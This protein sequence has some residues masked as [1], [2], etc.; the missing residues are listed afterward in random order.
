MT[1]DR[2]SCPDCDSADRIEAIS[3]VNRRDFLRT[4]GAVGAAASVGSLGLWTPDRAL[5]AAPAVSSGATPES[6]VKVLYEMLKPEQRSKVCYE[7]DYQDPKRGLLRTHVANNWNIN[8]QQINGDFYTDDQ[9]AVIRSIFEG[10]IQPEWHKRIY[11]QLSDDAGGY[12]EDQSLAIFGTPG[13]GKFEFVMTGRHM[14][15]RC[16]GDSADS[17]AFGGPIFYGHAAD[18]FNEKADHPGNV[19]WPQAVAANKVYAM[20]DEKQRKAALVQKLPAE[21]K[22]GFRGNAGGFPGIPVTELSSDQRE[23]LQKVLQVLVEPYR[24]SDRDEVIACLKAQGGLD[25][26]SLAFYQDGDIGKDSVWDCWRLEGPSFVWYFRG[27]PHVHVW[28]NVASDP[29]VKLN[30]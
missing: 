26:C 4:A 30:A 3:P 7:W 25:K 8:D 22:V 6:L 23:E 16:D 17:V 29:S 9:R 15:L 11:Q 10:I 13:S 2:H 28:V 21:N 12:G 5:A 20:M 19:F 1:R 27:A 14:T 18:G 24:Q